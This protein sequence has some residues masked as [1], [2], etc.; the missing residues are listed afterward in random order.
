[1]VATFN[2]FLYVLIP[3]LLL[4]AICY[5]PGK[6]AFYLYGI[7]LK[8]NS[9]PAYSSPFNLTLSLVLSLFI[10]ILTFWLSSI[11]AN[12]IWELFWPTQNTEHHVL[13]VNKMLFSLLV[14][15]ASTVFVATFAYLTFRDRKL[16]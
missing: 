11:L 1:M 5:L 14:A 6:L 13:P 8:S 9:K 12:Y 4:I 7:S 16:I 10:A 15:L 2:V 3:F